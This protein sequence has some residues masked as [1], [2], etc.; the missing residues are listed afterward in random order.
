RANRR[1][2]VM[3]FC[4]ADATTG[5]CRVLV[6]E[7]WPA[8]WTENLPPMRFLKDGK[9]FIWTSERTGWKNFYLH[10]LGCKLL[11]TLT[12]NPFE[13]ASI[14]HVDES[15]SLPDER[16]DMV[17]AGGQTR[18]SPRASASSHPGWLDYL[19]HS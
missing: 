7:Q 17:V 14:V 16:G 8:T 6:R 2:N 18:D 11:A 15:G 3:E 1:Q 9:R 10:N 4:A 5:N 13:V 12:E 19:A